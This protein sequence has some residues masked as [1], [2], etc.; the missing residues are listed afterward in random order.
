[1]L[2]K[3]KNALRITHDELDDEIQRNI[4]VCLLDLE[5]VGVKPD[6]NE[7]L[8]EKAVELYCKYMFDFMSQAERFKGNYESLRDAMSLCSRYK[9]E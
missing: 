7:L 5:R 6:S 9:D 8:V 4:D 2:D 1:M 3:I